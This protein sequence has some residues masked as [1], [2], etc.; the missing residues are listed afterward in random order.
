MNGGAAGAEAKMFNFYRMGIFLHG[1]EMEIMEKY[2]DLLEARRE[3]AYF[4]RRLYAKNLTSCSGGNISR[5]VP[6]DLVLVTPSALDKGELREDQV[7]LVRLDGENL[8]ASLKPTIEV[9]MHLA[10]YRARPDVQAVVH[11]HPVFATTFSCVGADIEAALTPETIMTLG[12]IAKAPYRPAGTRELAE[13]TAAALGRDNVALMRSHGVVTAGSTM[14]K[15]FDRLEVTEIA[16]Q[17][18]WLARGMGINPAMSDGEKRAM[19]ALLR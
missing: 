16:A 11:A 1:L 13:A 15:A 6:G 14:L 10:I 2:P 19:L 9:E 18:T 3:V 5:R 8:T 12:N 17:M 4:M 7:V